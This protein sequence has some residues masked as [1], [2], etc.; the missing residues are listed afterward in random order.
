MAHSQY[1]SN[2]Y[3]Y[4]A[5]EDKG[6]PLSEVTVTM[7]AGMKSGSVLELVGGKY[8]WLTAINAANAV[9]VLAD[10]RADQETELTAGDHTLQVVARSAGVGRGYLNFA[11]AF[12]ATAQGT[13]EAALLA[14][15]IKTEETL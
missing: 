8:V 12:D 7:Q 9:A 10:T 6:Y 13:A 14:V 2:V 5:N 1:L 3:L 15:G 11:D 4:G